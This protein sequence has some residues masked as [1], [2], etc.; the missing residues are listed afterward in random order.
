MLDQQNSA[1]ASAAHN[2]VLPPESDLPPLQSLVEVP[3][4]LAHQIDQLLSLQKRAQQAPHA[5]SAPRVA[6][7]S[8]QQTLNAQ[9]Q[10]AAHA[11]AERARQQHLAQSARS[12]QKGH[13][14]RDG[15]AVAGEH[16]AAGYDASQHAVR[17]NPSAA[18]PAE[19]KVVPDARSQQPLQ[20]LVQPPPSSPASQQAQPAQQ[21]QS[22]P[23]PVPQQQQAQHPQPAHQQPQPPSA[24]VPQPVP[25]QAVQPQARLTPT[26]QRPQ[27][28]AQLPA[29]A[30]QQQQTTALYHPQT[31]LQQQANTQI[32]NIPWPQVQLAATAYSKYKLPVI[33]GVMPRITLPRGV[34]LVL[35]GGG[36]HAFYTAGVLEAFMDVGVMFPYIASVSTAS[37]VCLSY[38]SG[39]R[40]RNRLIVERLVGDPR[41]YNTNIIKDRSLLNFDFIFNTIPKKYLY[42]DQNTF[43]RVQ[44]RLLTGVLDCR[45]GSTV[46]FEKA[47]L[48]TDFIPTMASC[49]S[50]F[51]SKMVRFDNREL[52]EGGILD[53]IPIERSVADGNH[54]HVIVLTKNS[55]YVK[56]PTKISS[57]LRMAY[58]KYPH[59]VWAL[60][61]HHDAYNRQV[62]LAERLERE[63]RALIIR[64]HSTVDVSQIKAEPE[65]LLDL[66][67]EGH[68][69][70][71]LAAD[72]LHQIFRF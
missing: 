2:H 14:I 10:A 57:V 48:G 9:R 62:L 40:G 17:S 29:Y 28:Q 8:P 72:K 23:Q 59:L 55:G 16:T 7:Q 26:H 27:P 41:Y 67:D 52:L 30:Q 49:S 12:V 54:F 25:Q 39:Q 45:E 33:P 58:H 69:D 35:E 34:G 43:D 68:L 64:P 38:L 13:A 63:G 46:W 15:R 66:H 50:P 4:E 31:F 51:L 36:T 44:T 11:A 20:S 37:K 71:A 18:L 70:G 53:P 47:S 1:D 56:N 24:Q 32:Q 65:K 19:P 61:A 42:W 60:K 21:Q 5:A 6:L 3:A 22:V